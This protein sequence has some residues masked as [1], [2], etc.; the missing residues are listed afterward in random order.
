MKENIKS[1]IT[2]TL[3]TLIAGALL[4]YVYELT[5]EPI[6]AKTLEAKLDAYHKVF[7]EAADFKEDPG[8]NLDASRAVLDASGYSKETVDEC[9]GAYD[10][11]GN[12]LG[13][14]LSVTTSEGYGGD[15]KISM[16]VGGDGVLKGIEILSISETAGLGMKADTD[17]FKD[18]FTNRNVSK[19]SYTKTGATADYEIDAISGA[20]ITTNAMVNAVNAGI[21]Y[22]G[23]VGGQ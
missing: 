3:I 18:Q 7:P 8:V 22:A 14:V 5:K 10:A 17:E 9:L 13:Y 4:G 12:K 16:G 15:I 1:I 21:E 19:F 20:T 6:A 2:L 11:S 23:K